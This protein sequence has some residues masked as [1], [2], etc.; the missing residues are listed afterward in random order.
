MLSVV[1]E[2]RLRL[3]AFGGMAVD[4][5]HSTCR[6]P[7]SESIDWRNMLHA[8]CFETFYEWCIDPIDCVAYFRDLKPGRGNHELGEFYI[9]FVEVFNKAGISDLAVVKLKHRVEEHKDYKL[10]IPL[11]PIR[12]AAENPKPGDEVITG[13]WGLTGLRF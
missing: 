7:C 13:G 9:P 4:R 12:L 1:T 5:V 3:P 10:G 11:Q 8:L 2:L 6:I